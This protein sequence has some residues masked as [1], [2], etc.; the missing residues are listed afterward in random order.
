M[1]HV[2]FVL[3]AWY[4]VHIAY[5][6]FRRSGSTHVKMLVLNPGLAGP[7]S[8]SHGGMGHGQRYTAASPSMR[9]SV[10][11]VGVQLPPVMMSH[12]PAAL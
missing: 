3:S 6:A 7:S 11:F 10:W 12:S 5:D 2:T 1:T 8:I 9:R 4:V